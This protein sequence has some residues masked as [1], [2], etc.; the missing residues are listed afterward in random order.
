MVAPGRDQGLDDQGAVVGRA[1]D[2]TLAD[3]DEQ[4]D[5][6]AVGVVEEQRRQLVRP[7]VAERL[8]QQGGLG[9]EVAVEGAVADP[10]GAG[11]VGDAGALEP[12]RLERRGCSLQQPLA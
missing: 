8:G 12:P 1:L 6:R 2:Q 5:D 11:D 9:A 10:G 3:G 4:V 7:V